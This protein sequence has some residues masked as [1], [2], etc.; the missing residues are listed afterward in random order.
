MAKKDKN[1]NIELD[2][3]RKTE[4][5]NQ[6]RIHLNSSEL[7]N[8]L[9]RY[10]ATGNVKDFDEAINKALKKELERDRSKGYGYVDFIKTKKFELNTSFFTTQKRPDQYLMTIMLSNGEGKVSISLNKDELSIIE[11]LR[12]QFD[13][14]RINKENTVEVQREVVQPEPVQE[15]VK[16]QP[17]PREVVLNKYENNIILPKGCYSLGSFEEG[18]ATPC[19]SKK[20]FW[21]Q[22]DYFNSINEVA[23]SQGTFDDYVT[24][25][26]KTSHAIGSI[27]KQLE[28]N[29]DDKAFNSEK[30]INRNTGI[31]AKDYYENVLNTLKEL[32]TERE[33]INTEKAA[34]EA[35]K[36]AEEEARKAEE[37][38]Q[39]AEEILQQEM[40]K[41]AEQAEQVAE[42]EQDIIENKADSV[43]EVSVPEDFF[44][45]EDAAEPETAEKTVEEAVEITEEAAEGKTPSNPTIEQDFDYIDQSEIYFPTKEE[46]LAKECA[47]IS[48]NLHIILRS[49]EY[50]DDI[51]K[52]FVSAN[53]SKL[54]EAKSEGIDLKSITF[55][56]LDSQGLEKEYTA[57]NLFNSLALSK[58][59]LELPVKEQA[60]VEKT[61]N[62]IEENQTEQNPLAKKENKTPVIFTI[63]EILSSNKVC[64]KKHLA[65]QFGYFKEQIVEYANNE[66]ISNKDKI[67]QLLKIED[68]IAKTVNENQKNISE[69]NIK[70]FRDKMFDTKINDNETIRDVFLSVAGFTE[71]FKKEEMTKV[72]ADFLDYWKDRVLVLKNNEGTISSDGLEYIINN[73]LKDCVVVNSVDL[74]KQVRIYANSH[75]KEL[76][77]FIEKLV[78]KDV[79]EEK[80]TETNPDIISADEKQPVETTEQ[81]KPKISIEDSKQ[82]FLKNWAQRYANGEFY[83]YGADKTQLTFEQLKETVDNC[84]VWPLSKRKQNKAVVAELD[85]T[86][87]KEINKEG[88][89]APTEVVPEVNNTQVPENNSPEVDVPVT[90]EVPN[91]EEEFEE[92][93][94]EPFTEDLEHEEEFYD[95]S[96]EKT[97][98]D[99]KPLT[100]EEVE[101]SINK[102]EREEQS[103][104]TEPNNK[105]APVKS[106]PLDKYKLSGNELRDFVFGRK[107]ALDKNG[108]LLL[109]KSGKPVDTGFDGLLMNSDGSS[110]SRNFFEKIL[111]LAEA[112]V[113][114]A[115][116]CL[117]NA[118]INAHEK[119]QTPGLTPE[120]AA[121]KALKG[122]IRSVD[123]VTKSLHSAMDKAVEKFDEYDKKKEKQEKEKQEEKQKQQEVKRTVK[124]ET[125]AEVRPQNTGKIDK[126]YIDKNLGKYSSDIKKTVEKTEEAISQIPPEKVRYDQDVQQKLDLL[127][128][129]ISTLTKELGEQKVQIENLTK[130]NE[131]LAKQNEEL[132][133]QNKQMEDKMLDIASDKVVEEIGND[134]TLAALIS[135]NTIPKGLNNVVPAFDDDPR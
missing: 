103:E 102:T 98:V 13:N 30:F 130:Q 54:E 89:P 124:S 44:V 15:V 84:E 49:E 7:Q 43:P 78:V 106:S 92:E 127:I 40:A 111:R 85:K 17:A 28:N 123:T 29:N 4:F 22:M 87:K 69:K 35:Q 67:K 9:F 74:T 73:P 121:R 86:Y 83:V 112:A 50:S 118:A 3:Q 100:P 24:T 63:D 20:H 66:T 70:K 117:V 108:N 132:V 1:K 80:Q 57:Q 26:E 61:E 128:Q 55:K 99:G 115:G 134:K 76:E 48:L 71:M 21:E 42:A 94:E 110:P 125:T 39:K 45:E 96:E 34:E 23:K 52:I 126:E 107:P 51:K 97:P 77:K 91:F 12:A 47:N 16:E 113:F 11:D 36:W 56:G 88:S 60:I 75:V 82:E 18:F 38:K 93:F 133:E 59:R 14:I 32:Q 10:A 8:T 114:V 101:D 135:G 104:K 105:K 2:A 119:E 120:A 62:S 53:L 81:Q 46:T 6:I 79:I 116:S 68:A 58:R 109:D 64:G 122:L 65:E 33:R 90:E 72:K 131:E 95:D 31:S 27:I 25:F 37:E 41:Q 19:P 129:Q 5:T